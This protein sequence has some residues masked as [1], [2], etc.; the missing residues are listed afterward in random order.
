MPVAEEHKTPFQQD[1]VPAIQYINRETGLQE[2]E[3]V[4]GEQALMFL[5]HSK[6]GACCVDICSANPGSVNLMR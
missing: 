3:R 6:P 1:A 2:T 5:Y 4:Y